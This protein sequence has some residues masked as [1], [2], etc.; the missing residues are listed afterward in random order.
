MVSSGSFKKL[1]DHIPST[2]MKQWGR[3]REER[4]VSGRERKREVERGGRRKGEKKGEG[5]QAGDRLRL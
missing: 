2:H 5:K 4:K 1:D 3:L